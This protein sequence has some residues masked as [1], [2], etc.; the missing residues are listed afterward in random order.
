MTDD[1][2]ARLER[3]LG[4]LNEAHEDIAQALDLA[5][6]DLHRTTLERYQQELEELVVGDGIG[7]KSGFYELARAE[8]ESAGRTQGQA[9]LS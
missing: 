6:T 5:P 2:R 9:S 1:Y 3:A 4:H 8:G 7:T